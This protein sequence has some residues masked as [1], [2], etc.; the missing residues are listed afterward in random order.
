MIYTQYVT[1]IIRIVI[2][3]D[4]LEM[5]NAITPP[6][7]TCCPKDFNRTTPPSHTKCPE[8]VNRTTPP[9]HTRC[10]ENINRSTPHSTLDVQKIPIEQHH[11]PILDV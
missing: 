6:S 3:A 11:H 8:D 7:H 5:V 9:S 4:P 1:F 10:P 2:K